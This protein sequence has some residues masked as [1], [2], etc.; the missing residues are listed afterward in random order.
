MSAH[1]VLFDQ[2]EAGDFY[3]IPDPGASGTI[4]VDRSPATCALK[5]A[6]S[7]TR[8]VAV[9]TKP[10]AQLLLY[11][12]TSSGTITVTVTGGFNEDAVTD[13]AFTEVGQF[14]KLEAIETAVGT[15]LWRKTSDYGLGNV[16]PADSAVLDELSGLTATADELNAVADAST[17]LVVDTTTQ[18]AVTA[19]A[20]AERDLVLTNTATVTVTLPAATAT[21][22]RY[23]IIRGATPATGNTVINSALTT[24]IMRGASL[25]VNTQSTTIGFV[26]TA[27]DNTITLNGTTQGGVIGTTVELLDRAAGAWHVN[28]FNITTGNPATPFSEV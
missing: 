27:T 16:A 7:E 25:A 19:A 24:E 6:T 10:G 3:Q 15:L 18:V 17:R 14:I 20:H 26:A 13:I 8:T 1:K 4:R 5:S 12:R 23:R 2:F 28:I 21:G 9:P 22:N 11:V